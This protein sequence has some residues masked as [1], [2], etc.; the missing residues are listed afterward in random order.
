MSTVS[1]TSTDSTP[2]PYRR[3]QTRHNSTLQAPTTPRTHPVKATGGVQKS[4]LTLKPLAPVLQLSKTGATAGPKTSEIP[5]QEVHQDILNSVKLR[6]SVDTTISLNPLFD[7]DDDSLQRFL[8]YHQLTSNGRNILKELTKL[9]PETGRIMEFH[10]VGAREYEVIEEVLGQTGRVS[11]PRLTY[12]YEKHSLLVEMPSAIHEAPFDCLK[13]SLG[14]AMSLLPY[15]H[16]LIYLM[17]H[18][19]SSL[20]VNRKSVTPDICITVTAAKGPTQ[21]MLVPFI[22]ECACSEDKDHAILKLK[23]TIAA[24]PH[25]KMAVLSLVHEAQPYSSP[26]DDSFASETF[27]KLKEPL[28]LEEFIT[29]RLP[30]CMPITVAD[31]SCCYISSVEFFVWVRG[32]DEDIIDLD[33]DDADHMAHGTLLPHIKMDAVKAMLTRGVGKI[34]DSFVSFSKQLNPEI[35]CT[36]LEEAVITLPTRWNDYVIALNNGADVTAWRRYQTWHEDVISD[37]KKDPSYVP[38]SNAGEASGSSH[39]RSKRKRKRTS[40]S[41]PPH[42]SK[43]AL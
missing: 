27:S 41:L 32:D 34:R 37:L 20:S 7:D 33:N 12:D 30:P 21:T 29:E 31:H 14:V 5:L 9:P 28:P 4:N 22:G 42:K 35:D 1:M 24:H 3:Y 43:R 16:D 38:P 15:E 18:M 23:N 25:A 6:A 19:N 39:E 8:R 26:D 11:K 10:D 17:I 36:E 13:E 40:T 2:E